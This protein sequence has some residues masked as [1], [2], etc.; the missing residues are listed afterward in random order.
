LK[1]P[2]K[3]R[4]VFKWALK[5]QPDILT[6]QEAH[7]EES[8]I[9]KW[10]DLW[11]GSISYSCGSNN[12][13]GVATLI[14]PNTDHKILKEEKDKEG[15]WVVI[16]LDIKGENLTIA[17]YYGPNLDDTHHME[18]M[19][20]KINEWG[21]DNLILTGDFNLVQNIT[22]DKKGGLPKTNFKCQKTLLNWMESNSITDIW[23]IKNPDKRRYTWISNTTPK[24][25]C[26]L[27]FH[28]MS[29]TMHNLYSDSDI[30]PGYMSDHACTTLTLE[31][32][33]GDRG[34]GFWKYNSTLA[35]DPSLRDQI[36][37][38]IAD[39][40]ADNPDTDD[41]LLWDLLKCKIR[42]TCIGLASRK[43]KEK[44]EKWKNIEKNIKEL[45]EKI[46]ETPLDKETI[47]EDLQRKLLQKKNELDNIIT[48]KV[49]GEILRSKV[50][51]HEEGHKASKMF[52]NLEKAR[53]E[54]KTIRKLNTGNNCLVTDMKEILKEEENFYHKL[55]KSKKDQLNHHQ[56]IIEEEIWGIEGKKIT[57][58]PE[59]LTKKIEE[60]ELWK[61][62]EESPLNKSPGTDGLTTEFYRDFWPILKTFLIN[63]L[64]TGLQR[65]K[66]N[67][68]QRRGIIS[69]IPKPQKDLD[70]LKN[71]RPITL[72]NQD[73]KYLT[74]ILANRLEKT[75]PDIIS[76]DQ[77]GFVKGRYIG[78]NIQR[79]QNMIEL[80]KSNQINGSLINIDFEKAFDT[81]EW[82]FIGKALNKMGYPQK[83]IIWIETLYKDIETCVINNGHTTS[84]F[85]P[86]RG[87][88]QGCPISPYLFIITT[89]ILNRRLK[90]K[91][92]D[93]GI[94]DENSNNYFIAQFADDTSFS[95]KNEKG[96]MHKLFHLLDEYGNISGLRL[97]I[98]KTEILHLG[99][100]TIKDVP[101]RY[102]KYIKPQVN[103]LGCKI[104]VNYEDTTKINIEEIKEKLK[105]LIGVWKSRSTNLS[106]KIAITKSILIPQFT[107][108]L[109]TM[110]S[111][112]K[113]LIQ[114]I[115]RLLYDFIY[116]DGSEK[117]KRTTLM[118]DY[119]DGGFKMTDLESYIE[120][121]KISWIN[122]LINIEGIW[123][124]EILNRMQIKPI[125]FARLNIEYKDLPFSF[126]KNSMWDEVMKIW[127]KENFYTPSNIDEIYN[128]PI[129]LN[130]HIKVNGKVINW[131]KWKENRIYWIADILFEEDNSLRFLKYEE[132]C[133]NEESKINWMEYNSLISAI[134][135]SWKSTIKEDTQNL[136]ETEDHKLIDQILNQKRPMNYMYK[137]IIKK[138]IT[139]PK[140]SI[141]KWKRD[142]SSHLDLTE[143]L[144][145]HNNNHLCSVNSKL[146]SFNC[147]FLN[148]NVPYNRRLHKMGLE[149]TN[150]CQWC[151]K[152]ETILHL[153]W[154]CKESRKI[155][156]KLSALYKKT[157]KKTFDLSKEKCL[158][159]TGTNMPVGRTE[160]QKQRLLCLLTKHF[161]HVN[162]CKGA[163]ELNPL[164]WEMYIKHHLYIEM[165][166]A[167][168]WGAINEFSR[169][170]IE[171]I[172][173]IEKG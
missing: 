2:G 13:K 165:N 119:K 64:N 20:N 50:Q 23:R 57:T 104:N 81:I 73:Y 46:Q 113:K 3:R 89:E 61:V 102:K 11:K 59:D 146:R 122:R 124:Q 17:N 101:H 68:S 84:F 35:K 147:N 115:N 148:R 118:G 160:C 125:E 93:M 142:L 121:I 5:K 71:W 151:T 88:R 12:S 97:N 140:E 65:G 94:T 103:Y 85:K 172:E 157:S 110:T 34:K 100:S 159:G 19:L 130:S 53:G 96:V 117:I 25:M 141:E 131:K 22:M 26:R 162:K 158:L 108:V 107:Y 24:I 95:I 42:G 155:W 116:N 154:E 28:L 136:E 14:N 32:K 163:K 9:N 8:D 47:M 56:R 21:T 31:I 51:W 4:K 63:S 7:I 109:S 170:W 83:F 36:R 29:D 132:L 15:R 49:Q 44:K 75:L 80:C 62:I 76:T 27:D 139:Q 48:E 72:L 79:I 82:E 152:E 169:I 166:R 171:W 128:Q 91:I 38:T 77:S 127:C 90:T 60:N 86:E 45:E 135:K 37:T 167:L 173:W 55:Y 78:C 69:L 114:E 58:D 99:Q 106:G 156:E 134:P 98:D 30:V 129:W 16:N 41:C 33:S 161:I 66:L 168:L 6:I 149:P 92:G 150:K 52:L 133:D 143:I 105:G 164:H 111:P 43:N 145:G 10:T 70:L 120:A 18:E 138:K 153:Y 87:V 144:S 112:D 54:S 74:K 40:I 39:T 123:K 137:K 67:I 126:P 1:N